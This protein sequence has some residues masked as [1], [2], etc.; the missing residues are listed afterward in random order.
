MQ[1][2]HLSYK[3]N[4]YM[5]P[6]VGI[7]LLLVAFY[8][9]TM[10]HAQEP[11]TETDTKRYQRPSHR[12]T[13]PTLKL[14]SFNGLTLQ[15]IEAKLPPEVCQRLSTFHIRDSPSAACGPL[16][17]T[18]C[19]S[20]LRRFVQRAVRRHC[21]S[22]GAP[23]PSDIIAGKGQVVSPVDPPDCC[24]SSTGGGTSLWVHLF[25]IIAVGM[26]L[27]TFGAVVYRHYR[28]SISSALK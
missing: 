6:K 17:R 27:G 15:E 19:Y 13:Y 12:R 24:P 18:A 20:K 25:G 4:K 5:A 16:Q 1:V 21:N 11:A 7:L 10:I 3:D 2:L 8:S 23:P 26:T 28:S 22:G 9:L 14:D